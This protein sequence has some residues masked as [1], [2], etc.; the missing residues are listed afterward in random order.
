MKALVQPTALEGKSGSIWILAW[1][2][3]VR[4]G[5]EALRVRGAFPPV[6][7]KLIMRLMSYAGLFLS[8]E[9]FPQGSNV[10][11]LVIEEKSGSARSSSI[12][13]ERR[14]RTGMAGVYVCNEV[15]GF[16]LGPKRLFETLAAFEEA[17]GLHRAGGGCKTR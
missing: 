4:E 11:S 16:P 3:W 7:L 14:L 15:H 2:H 10:E 9:L 5:R 13:F 12:V 6:I 8:L 1:C 17:M